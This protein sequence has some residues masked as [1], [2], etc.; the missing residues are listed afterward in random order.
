MNKMDIGQN[1]QTDMF[2]RTKMGPRQSVWT[3]PLVCSICSLCVSKSSEHPMACAPAHFANWPSPHS[4]HVGR[5][6]HHVSCPLLTMET[7]TQR[8]DRQDRDNTGSRADR[9]RR[10]KI[11]L[12]FPLVDIT[13]HLFLFFSFLSFF[14]S[15]LCISS[16]LL[17]VFVISPSSLTTLHSSRFPVLVTLSRTTPLFDTL[18]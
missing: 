15:F 7:A 18:L 13:I 8:Q 6:W 16:L 11:A 17:L 5:L 10:E 12:F 1:R 2:C 4:P 9:K 3:L 14:L